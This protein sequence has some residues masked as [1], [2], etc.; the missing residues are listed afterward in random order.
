MLR[1]RLGGG[2]GGSVLVAAPDS[3]HSTLF[4]LQR[5]L[6]QHHIRILPW[7]LACDIEKVLTQYDENLFADPRVL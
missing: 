6:P 1:L 5:L 7:T 4:E 2:G 3:A